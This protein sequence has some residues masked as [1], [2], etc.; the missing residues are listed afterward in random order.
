LS[1]LIPASVTNLTNSLIDLS[2]NHLCA[3][4]PAVVEFLDLHA[5][6]WEQ[7]QTNPICE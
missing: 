2:Q 6:G 5:P 3:Q 7:T 4:D 1:G